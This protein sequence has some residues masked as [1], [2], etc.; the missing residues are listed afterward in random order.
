MNSESELHPRISVTAIQADEVVWPIGRMGRYSPV[1]I[2]FKLPDCSYGNTIIVDPAPAYPHNLDLVTTLVKA[3]GDVFPPIGSSFVGFY[4]M[5]CDFEDHLNGLIIQDIA[6]DAP[7]E[8]CIEKGEEKLVHP[9][10]IGIT[11]AAKR[12]PIHPAMTRYLVAHEYGHAVAYML[13]RALDSERLERSYLELREGWEQGSIPS[14]DY[15]LGSWHSA[16]GEIFAN[17]FRILL[18][19][20]EHEFWPHDGFHHPWNLQVAPT[21]LRWWKQACAACG[22][23]FRPVLPVHPSYAEVLKDLQREDDEQSNP[24]ASEKN[25]GTTEST[26]ESATD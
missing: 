10:R 4:T 21:I 15:K 5:P 3:C 6:W 18:M 9:L 2:K 12:I 22:I 13:S 7:K 26:I 8:K 23:P 1:E 24:I 17:D 16:P 14:S 11:L 25:E 20:S 19:G